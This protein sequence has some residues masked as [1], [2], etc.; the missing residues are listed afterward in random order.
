MVYLYKTNYKSEIICIVSS[1]FWRLGLEVG[2]SR[3]WNDGQTMDDFCFVLLYIFAMLC[4]FKYC[5]VDIEHVTL[6]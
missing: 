2:D 4:T 3:R 1:T 5:L 6:A